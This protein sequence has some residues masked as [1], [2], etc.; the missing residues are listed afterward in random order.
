MSLSERKAVSEAQKAGTKQS[1]LMS[2]PTEAQSG[3]TVQQTEITSEV[4]QSVF[5]Q[6]TSIQLSVNNVNMKLSASLTDSTYHYFFVE[7]R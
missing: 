5:G 7:K 2:R 1:H 3:H 6:H 4:R